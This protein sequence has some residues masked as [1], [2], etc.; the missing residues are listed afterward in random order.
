MRYP[1]YIEDDFLFPDFYRVQMNHPGRGLEDPVKALLDSLD[2]A[3]LTSRIKKGDTVAIG[4]G[5]RGIAN[6]AQL[7]TALCQRFRDVGAKPHIIPAMGSHGSA[8]AEGQ[9][10]VLAKLGITEAVCGAP[11][12]S[13]MDVVRVGE[14]MG[15]VPVYFSKDALSMDHS[16][17][18]NRIKPHT[19]FKGAV[20]SG[21]CKMLCIGMGK[22]Q[23]AL[24]Y[25]NMALKYGFFPLLK[26]MA[27]KIISTTNFRFGIALVED[28]FEDT[29]V[30][31]PVP[32]E[33]VVERESR[34]LNIARDNF[35]H[36]PFRSLDALIIREIGKDIS[37][38]GMDP[39]VTGRTYDLMEDDF[40]G[41]LQAGRIAIL[42]LSEKTGGNAIGLGNADIIT[43]KV[44][45]GLDYESTVMNALTSISLRKAYIPIRLPN[46]Q[47]AIQAAFTTLGP[48]SPDKARAVIIQDTLHTQGF[49]ASQALLPEVEAMENAEIMEKK[50]LVFDENGD[51]NL[52]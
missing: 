36:L 48:L 11:V 18:I 10:Q 34:L 13:T 38:S 50:N 1:K 20:E 46:D 31:E 17:C 28:L 47:K 25:H 32:G 19:K 2:D 33:E 5:S 43:E 42:N 40:S 26:T 21:L 29:M 9:V 49:W 8:T 52:T 41:I 4:V 15:E 6:I 3:F 39:N 30:I 37:G 44:F 12:V 16:V 22:H 23:G 45:K 27:E 35:P 7:V 14:V 51:L 24:A